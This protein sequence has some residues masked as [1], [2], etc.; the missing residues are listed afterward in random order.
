MRKIISI[1]LALVVGVILWYLFLKP[2]DYQVNFKAKAIPGTI[3]ETVK[4]WNKGFDSVIPIDYKT[5]SHFEQTILVNDSV[6]I[7][8]WKITR[9]HDSLSEVEVNIKDLSHS[10]GNR[11]SVPF[12]DT[13]FEKGSRKLL[14]DFNSLLNEHI[15]GFKVS[16][17]NEEETFS[18]FCAC[19]KLNTS[20]EDKAKGMMANY[21]FLDGIL[22]ENEVQLN[23][24]PF[25]EV[26]DWDLDNNLLSYNFCNPIVRSEKLPDHP[27][28]EYKRMFSKNALKAV[29]HGNYITSDR[30]WYALLD[31]AKEN[32]ISI[33]KKPIEVFHNNP[34]IGGNELEWTTEVFMPIKESNE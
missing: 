9:V 3:Y 4:A 2:Q 34:H 19:V 26:L 15:K 1:I 32:N 13:D 6:H 31:Y 18:S 24:P 10:L 16:I 29:Y 17:E 21:N 22:A 5:P 14:L 25:V 30:A 8:D 20:P 23:G 11:L 27:D 12:S 33:E 28:I 7:Y